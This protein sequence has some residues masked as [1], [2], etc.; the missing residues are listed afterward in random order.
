MS[1][2]AALVSA[3]LEFFASALAVSSL[4][5]LVTH[6]HFLDNVLD[7]NQFEPAVP[8]SRTVTLQVELSTGY[9]AN[10][11]VRDPGGN[12]LAGVRVDDGKGKVVTTAADGFLPD[13]VPTRSDYP[14][15][16]FSNPLHCRPRPTPGTEQYRLE[17]TRKGFDDLGVY[18][19]PTSLMT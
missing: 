2:V 4:P 12:P 3:R 8:P 17:F 15:K 1:S 19:P 11:C 7:P 5:L 18:P 13:T 9:V 14:C 10:G 16:A 6:A